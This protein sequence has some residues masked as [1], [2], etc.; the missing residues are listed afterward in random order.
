LTSFCA[1]KEKVINKKEKRGVEEKIFF[2]KA[3]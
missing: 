3:K 2:K 1:Q